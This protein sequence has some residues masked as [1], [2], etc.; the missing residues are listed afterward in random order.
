VLFSRLSIL[1]DAKSFAVVTDALRAC[2]APS[3]SSSSSLAPPGSSG[4]GSSGPGSSGTGN[5][6]TGQQRSTSSSTAGVGSRL[7][8]GEGGGEELK[9]GVWVALRQMQR[10]SKALTNMALFKGTVL[11]RQ[12]FILSTFDALLYALLGDVSDIM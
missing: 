3:S 10:M 8:E 1:K 7:A 6:R 11:N 2:T 4:P 9:L 12:P 5:R